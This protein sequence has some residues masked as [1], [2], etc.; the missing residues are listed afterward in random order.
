MADNGRR[1]EAQR[2]TA[3]GR[4]ATFL[5]RGDR[6]VRGIAAAGSEDTDANRKEGTGTQ[7]QSP[8]ER[9]RVV[10]APA[11]TPAATG[12]HGSIN[13][14]RSQLFPMSELSHGGQLLT[15]YYH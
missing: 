9:L 7:D 6:A 10:Y 8:L 5:A 15:A 14:P 13:C 2:T 3:I 12:V 1:R 11:S 4:R